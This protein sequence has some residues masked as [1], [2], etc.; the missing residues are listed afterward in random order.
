M[1]LSTNHDNA[2]SSMLSEATVKVTKAFPAVVTFDTIGS[3]MV[4][5]KLAR[6]LSIAL[7]TSLSAVSV[8][9]S[10][11]NSVTMLAVLSV[12]VLRTCL[13]PV[14]V[15]SWFSILRATSLSS[16]SG[17]APSKVAVTTTVGRSISGKFWMP[18]ALKPLRPKKVSSANSNSD[19]TG[20]RMDQAEIFMLHPCWQ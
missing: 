8:L 4:E 9:V 16:C 3:F 12:R 2:S 1:S 15:A 18:N 17:S 14:T 10:I 5:G 19:G 7:R 6:I 11:S 13:T 20:L